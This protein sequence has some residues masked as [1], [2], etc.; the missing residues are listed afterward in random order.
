MEKEWSLFCLPI[1]KNAHLQLIINLPSI[2]DT[3]LYSAYFHFTSNFLFC[4]FNGPGF[5]ACPSIYI[6][7][8]DKDLE[9]L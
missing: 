8:N 3:Y 9:T 6:L 5:S 4:L 2:Y 1:K 7:E